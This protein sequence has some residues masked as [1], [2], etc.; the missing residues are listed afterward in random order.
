M[1][2]AFFVLGFAP[3]PFVPTF[4]DAVDTVVL[5]VL[6]AF[7]NGTAAADGAPSRRALEE[8][9]LQEAAE[10]IISTC[11]PGGDGCQLTRADAKQCLLLHQGTPSLEWVVDAG[12]LMYSSTCAAAASTLQNMLEIC[13]AQTTAEFICTVALSLA[14]TARAVPGVCAMM[15]GSTP[16]W[17]KE[18]WEEWK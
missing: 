15:F 4:Q 8:L 18:K 1:L 17:C 2:A 3:D 9:S 12:L 5:H 10:V 16:T 13:N 7:A 14:I 6:A 11:A